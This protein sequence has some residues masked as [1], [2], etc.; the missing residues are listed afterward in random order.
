MEILGYLAAVIIGLTLGMI[1]GGGSIL[2]VP[3]LVYLFNIE[4][5]IATTWS[6]FIVGVTSFTGGVRAYAKKKVDFKTVS[7]FGFPSIF[8]I[9][10]T[11][12][13]LLPA[14]PDTIY[15]SES[16]TLSKGNFLMLIFSIVMLITAFVIIK[17]KKIDNSE[18]DYRATPH[19]KNGLFQLILLGLVVGVVTGLLG[20]GG[21]FLIIP[22]LVLILGMPMKIAVGTSL[23]IIAINSM[24]GFLFSLKHFEMNWKIILPFTFIAIIG[25]IAGSRFADKVA[26]EKLKKVFGWFVL[27]MAIFIIFKEI[28]FK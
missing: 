17:N 8:S 9:F 23:F 11:R 20:A 22:A 25:L 21:G 15:S 6:L 14:I 1:G 12:N 5:V 4:P 2:T 10:I 7:E 19:N 28:S 13:Y 3:V 26:G 18:D 16:F 24:F 27:L